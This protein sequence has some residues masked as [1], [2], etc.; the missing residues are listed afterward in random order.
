[1]FQRNSE[2]NSNF[3]NL[4]LNVNPAT[5]FDQKSVEGKFAWLFLN[6]DDETLPSL[7]LPQLVREL[8]GPTVVR[9]NYYVSVQMVEMTVLQ[10]LLP[11][12]PCLPSIISAIQLFKVELTENEKKLLTDINRRHCDNQFGAQVDFRNDF[13]VE[14]SDLIQYLNFLLFCCNKVRLKS[15]LSTDKSGFLRVVGTNFEVAFVV[16]E[17]IKFIPLFYLE[18]GTGAVQTRTVS[19]WDW[20]Y[21]RFCCEYQ[22]IRDDLL[23]PSTLLCV[24]IS[25]LQKFLPGQTRFENFW[26]ESNHLRL[27][28]PRAELRR[29]KYEG[30][31]KHIEDYPESNYGAYAYKINSVAVSTE[32]LQCINLFPF[33]FNFK[34]VALS[35]LRARLFPGHSDNQ[36]GRVLKRLGILL[37]KGNS[38]Q[39]KVMETSG[40]GHYNEDIPLLSVIDILARFREIKR[41]LN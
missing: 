1:M 13:L 37:Y 16:V 26:P 35:H 11:Q 4:S 2:M 5:P 15:L 14:A 20:L 39:R 7:C 38:C 3:Q 33:Q 8:R 29:E 32:E 30:A 24:S 31:L 17:G 28:Q 23:G 25:D 12:L 6:A 10:H 19:G 40:W 18:G 21:L 36:V 41:G 9:L 27:P 34:L 22:G